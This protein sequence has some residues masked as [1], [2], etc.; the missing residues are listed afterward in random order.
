MCIFTD[1]QSKT[2]QNNNPL[3]K[4]LGVSFGIAVTIGGTIGTGILRKPGQIAEYIAQPEWILFLWLLVGIYAV[5]GVLCAIELAVSM[6]LAG[7]WYVYARKAFGDYI[8]F[9]TGITSWLGT[10]SAL[11]FGAYTMSEYMAI[12]LPQMAGYE[13]I[14]SVAMLIILTGFHWMGTKSAGKSQEIL[15]IIKAV[16]LLVFVFIC[17]VY[18]SDPTGQSVQS[19]VESTLPGMTIVGV[20]GALQAIFYTYD[21]WHTATYFSEENTDPAKTLPKSMLWGVILIIIIYLL[22]NGAILYVLPMEEL[23]GVKL[24]AADAVSKVFPSISGKVITLFLRI[25]I[26]GIVNAQIMFAPRV[27]Y[28]MGRD[29]LFF[30]NVMSVNQMGTPVG[31]MAIT[32][33]LSIALILSGKNTCEKLSDIATF[34]FVLSYMAGFVALIRLRYAFPEM[35]RPFL[36]PLFPVLPIM[37]TVASFAFLVGAVYKD[38]QSA[39]YALVFLAVSYP[40]FR[41]IKSK[42]AFR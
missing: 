38:W 37:L 7:A 11:G 13:Q 40:L 23:I 34:F 20:I 12:L 14:L 32:S 24:A 9:V 15:A 6:P 39:I 16:G 19:T 5:L 41:L 30:N 27:I 29:R 8:G 42:V 35:P 26:L 33:I 22:V 17:F 1:K 25:S 28:S 10:V 36:S 31:A 2:M 21:G 18:G 4:L 3:L